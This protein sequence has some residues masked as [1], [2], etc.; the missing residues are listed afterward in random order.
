M[1][2]SNR[3]I[4]YYYDKAVITITDPFRFSEVVLPICIDLN[5]EPE[6][7]QISVNNNAQSSI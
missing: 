3:V 1:P 5:A 6:D 4:L 7:L 2:S